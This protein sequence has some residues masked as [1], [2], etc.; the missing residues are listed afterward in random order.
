MATLN[1][2]SEIARETLKALAASKLAPTPDNYARAYQEI[3]GL[4]Q[5]P[6]GAS[7][8]IEQLAQRLMQESPVNSKSS[9]ALKQ[10]LTEQN[11]ALCQIEMQKLMFL[12]KGKPAADVAWSSLIKD[13]LRQLEIPHKGITLTRKKEGIETVLARFTADSAVLNEKLTGLIRS[14]SSG[15]TTTNAPLEVID[16]LVEAAKTVSVTPVTSVSQVATESHQ[17]LSELR[18]LL[19]NTLEKT[20]LSHPELDTEIQTLARLVRAAENHQQITDLADQLRKF[21]LKMELRGGDKVR[22]QEGLLRLLRLLVENV[23]E[24]VADD[25]WTHGQITAFRELIEQPLD[26]HAIADA[27]R[28]LRDAIIKQGTLKQSLSDAKSTLKSL[29]TTFIDRLGNLT[30]STG[31]YHTKIEGY[32]LK[33]SG[34]D[35]IAELSTILSDIMQDTRVIQA[36]AQRTHEE[37]KITR[38]QANE[39]EERV[40]KLEKELES[41]SELVREDQLTGALNR[42]GLED[43]LEREFKRTDRAHNLI[44]VALLDI[45]NF[46]QLNDTLGHQGGDE[47]LIHLTK[48]IK[49][50][51]RPTDSVARY[52]GE[53]FLIILPDTGMQAAMEIVERLQRELTKKYFMHNNDRKLITFSAG[54]ALRNENEDKDDLI[55]RADKAMYHAKQTGKNRVVSAA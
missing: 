48:V 53:E 51:L 10:A 36:S 9:Q 43:T 6:S 39:A 38:K 1:S 24:L 37:L 31:D 26:K 33:I 42:R 19:A 44:S 7:A 8:V 41:V 47:A 30:E 23:S 52:G 14:W 21:W 16:T 40:K 18:E 46:K 15:G 12:D 17:L 29:M 22:I 4:P 35:N 45:D 28:N 20:V 25:K 49:E 54:V 32:S 50:T 11:W 2:P 5:A 55:G 13:L 34:T 3:S 27:E